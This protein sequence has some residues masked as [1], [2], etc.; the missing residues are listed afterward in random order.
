[1]KEKKPVE[2][3]QIEEKTV[4]E[5]PKKKITNFF[6][7]TDEAEEKTPIQ[8]KPVK[9]EEKEDI[10]TFEPPLIEPEEEHINKKALAEKARKER[11]LRKIKNDQEKQKRKL[12]KINFENGGN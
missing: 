9:I 8:E 12:S 1:M 3:K 5:K 7:R 2:D 10:K 11:A 4:E 6:K